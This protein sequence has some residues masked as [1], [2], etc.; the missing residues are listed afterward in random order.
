MSMP[1]SLFTPWKDPVSGVESLILSSRV[2]PV[3]QSFYFTQS[4]F[5]DDGRYLWF[6][7]AFP[8]SGDQYTGRQLGVVDFE[9]EKVRYYPETLFLDASPYV[10]PKTA[11]VYWVS[12]LDVWKRGPRAGDRPI[13]VNSFPKELA[14]NRRPLRIATHLTPS[15]NGQ[16]FAID[17]LIGNECFIGDLPIDGTRPFNLWYKTDRCYNHAQFSP[18]DPDLM[19]IAQDGWFDAATGKKG[20]CVDRLWLIRRGEELRAIYPNSPSNLRGHE[21][22]DS[23]GDHVWYI[24]YREGTEKVNIRT[25]QRTNI[26]PAGH[27]HSHSDRSGRYLAGNVNP[28]HIDFNLWW[29][30]FF[31]V[32][33]GK[34][35]RIVSEVPMLPNVWDRYQTCPQPHFCLND[36]WIVY[37]TTVLGRVD[38]AMVSVAQLVERTS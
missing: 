32:A 35:V 12:G 5:S 24:N 4:G 19:L 6:Y 9:K 29:V 1:S 7:V 28:Q 21:W 26:W 25:G 33:T 37:T 2:A 14:N 34:E 17:A 15:A 18:T 36:Q 31:N 11:E 20:D 23:D 27:T 38:V 30:S 10:D 22:W 3:Q 13:L 16:S 8:P